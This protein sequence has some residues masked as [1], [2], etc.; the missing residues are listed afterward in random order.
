MVEAIFNKLSNLVSSLISILKIMFRS[1]LFYQKAKIEEANCFILGNGPS[2]S[3]SLE[4]QI[5]LF[6]SSNLLCVNGFSSTEYFEILKPKYFVLAAPEIWSN[7]ATDGENVK[8]RSA[9]VDNL[10]LKTNWD[11]RLFLPTNSRKNK[12]FIQ[13]IEQNSN[14]TIS[15]FNTTPV[16]G[17][18]EVNWVLF[19]LGLGMP[20]PHNVI[21]PALIIAINSK[22]KT[23][24]LFGVDHSWIPLIHVDQ[25]NN[26]LLA[27][28]HFYDEDIA[29]PTPMTHLGRR[30]RMLH[31]ILEKF[32]FTFKS[33]VAI[34]TYADKNNVDIF[35]CTENSFIDAFTRKNID[36][37]WQE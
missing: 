32:Y 4:D 22:V 3:K 31:E 19:K 13:R 36:D 7:M 15:Y 9:M 28:K 24:N 26:A 34:R 17:I 23:I 35:N 25:N 30:K 2:L 33:Y 16:A 21:I 8:I 20:R 18:P 12:K 14:I 5:D 1:S 27:Q 11:L 10:L 6:K 29:K 37:I